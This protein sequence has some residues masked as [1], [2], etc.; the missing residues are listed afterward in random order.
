MTLPH[1]IKGIQNLHRYSDTMRKTYKYRLQNQ[2]NTIKIGNMLDDMYQIHVH[3]MKLQRRYYKMFGNNLSYS[4]MS[5]H[6]T[7]L[8]GRTKPHWK[9]LPS[10]VSQNVVKRIADAYSRFL[11]NIKEHSEGKTTIKVGRP[12]IKPQHKYNSMTFT[13]KGYTLV[14]NRFKINCIDTWYTF[15]KHREMKGLIKTITLKRDFCGDYWICFSCDY[16]DDTEV[17]I[18]TGKIAGLDFGLKTFLTSSDGV[19]IQSP[20]YLKQSLNKVKSL[21]KSLNR[22]V[23]KSGNWYRAKRTLS[24]QYRKV[25]RQRYDWQW[26]LADRL[27]TEYDTIIV[28]NLNIEAMKRLWG[29]KVSDLSFSQFVLI[30]EQKC[31]KHGKTFKQIGKW[32]PTTKP[33]N[34]CGYKNKNLSLK[35][36]TWTCPS[37]NTTHDRDINAAI[38]IKQVGLAT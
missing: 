34:Q 5:S 8:K 31:K 23:Y 37:C 26:K 17:K 4:R 15:H 18:K 14:D 24:R 30:L 6:L 12:H 21:H 13:Q 7:K 10:Q 36:R 20:Q 38:N 16:V 28:E 25:S 33:C 22:K 27:C 19:K 32:I 11:T 9:H 1:L 3:F 2:T 35:D 29:R